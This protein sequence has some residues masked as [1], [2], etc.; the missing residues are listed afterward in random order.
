M[1][2]ADQ[3]SPFTMV[4]GRKARPGPRAKPPTRTTPK[5]KKTTPTKIKNK[6]KAT[7]ARTSARADTLEAANSAT[8]KSRHQTALPTR[9]INPVPLPPQGK[10]VFAPGNGYEKL[11]GPYSWKKLLIPMKN[12]PLLGSGRGGLSYAYNGM[13]NQQTIKGPGPI[14]Y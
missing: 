4:H 13:G 8:R 9:M 11:I 12:P 2:L 14:V 1:L 6:K 7:P 3:P 10:G 5:K